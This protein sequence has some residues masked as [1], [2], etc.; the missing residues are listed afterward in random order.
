MVVEVYRLGEREVEAKYSSTESCSQVCKGDPR[1]RWRAETSS[2][3]KGVEDEQLHIACYTVE[4][5]NWR[6]P[7]SFEPEQLPSTREVGTASKSINQSIVLE[8]LEWGREMGCVN[9]SM[10]FCMR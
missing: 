9:H 10:N 8:I 2:S 5:Q 1:L 7:G 3:G 6:K 4:Q